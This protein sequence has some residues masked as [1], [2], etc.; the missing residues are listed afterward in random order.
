MQPYLGLFHDPQQLGCPSGLV[1]VVADLE[2][3]AYA[4]PG[5]FSA[6]R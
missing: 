5:C 3:E 4:V 2:V 6:R 1:T